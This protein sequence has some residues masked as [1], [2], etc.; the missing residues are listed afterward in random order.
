MQKS[1]SNSTRVGRRGQTNKERK[2]NASEVR[3]NKLEQDD[4]SGLY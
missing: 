1:T 4:T 2:L 3:L